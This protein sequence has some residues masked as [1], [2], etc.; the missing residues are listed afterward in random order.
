[1]K[2]IVRIG[3]MMAV[4]AALVM[5]GCA[6]APEEESAGPPERRDLPEFF[7]NPPQPED[8]FVGLGMAKLQDDNLSR[9][10]A[11]AR[12]RADIAAQVAVS[13]ETM[14]TDYAQESGADDNTQT[15]TFV[16]RVTKEVADIELRGAVTKEQYPSNDGTWYV[17]VYFPRASM[18][19]NVGE[20]FNRNE[21]AAFA[22]FKAQQA[23]ERLNAEVENNPPRSAG[24]D[25]PVNQ[26]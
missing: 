25:S 9:T 23:L 13:V 2:Y 1:M 4:I 7:L 18:I 19:D 15:L 24:M 21:D 11:L 16:E 5:T 10:T 3:I 8:Q 17:M 22:E 12:A 6:S 26:N 14:L 20:V